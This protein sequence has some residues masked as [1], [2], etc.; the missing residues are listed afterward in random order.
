V[1]DFEIKTETNRNRFDITDLGGSK[2][3]ILLLE[4]FS[5][6]E[7]FSYSELALQIKICFKNQFNKSI[8]TN[9]AKELISYC[10]NNNWLIQEQPKSP[11]KLNIEDIP[12]NEV[13][14]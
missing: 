12:L 5:T 3:K 11:Y 1:D 10:K 7:F 13:P 2:T 9:R 14:F 6:K 8:G 4:V